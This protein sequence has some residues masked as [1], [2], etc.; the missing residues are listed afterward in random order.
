MNIY[1][2]WKE[3]LQKKA[4]QIEEKKRIAK[5]EPGKGPG[6]GSGT[7]MGMGRPPAVSEAGLG[8]KIRKAVFGHRK[9]GPKWTE[10]Y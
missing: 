7:G 4:Q 9:V 3:V 10:S 8:Q 5:V 2:L 6:R 1:D